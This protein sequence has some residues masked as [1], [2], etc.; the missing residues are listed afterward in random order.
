VY[1]LSA[2]IMLVTFLGVLG[3]Q[4]IAYRGAKKMALAK[5]KGDL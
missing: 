1:A 4:I 3:S 5:D 2:V